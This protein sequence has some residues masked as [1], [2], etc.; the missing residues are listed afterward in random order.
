[1]SHT[2]IKYPEPTEEGTQ[3]APITFMQALK[4]RF[5]HMCYEFNKYR[6]YPP[7]F[8]GMLMLVS[9]IQIYAQLLDSHFIPRVS[10]EWGPFDFIATLLDLIRLSP[11][12]GGTVDASLTL[13]FVY[14]M[15]ALVILFILSFYYMNHAITIRKLYFVL[16]I[17]LAC[18]YGECLLWVL[19]TPICELYVDIYFCTSDNNVLLLPSITCWSTQHSIHMALITIGLVLNIVA[20]FVVA[21]Y[22]NESRPYSATGGED[23]LARLDTN[24]EVYFCSYRVIISLL[25]RWLIERD[26]NWVLLVMH[27]FYAT[28]FAYKYYRYVPYYNAT[29]SGLNGGCIVLHLWLIVNLI[30]YDFLGGDGTANNNRKYTGVAVVI[31]LGMIIIYGSAW[32]VRKQ[33][34]RQKLIEIHHAKITTEEELDLYVQNLLQLYNLQQ[35]KTEDELLLR[36]IVSRHKAECMDVDCPLQKPAGELLYHPATE[37]ESGGDKTNVRDKIVVLSL[38]NSIFKERER[39]LGDQA[40]ACLHLIFGNFLFKEM[41]NIH[42]AIVEV[43]KAQKA[44]PSYQQEISIYQLLRSIEEYLVKRYRHKNGDSKK[45]GDDGRDQRGPVQT[46]ECWDVMVVIKFENWLFQLVKTVERCAAEHIEFWS[47]LE[48]LL[49]DLNELNRL[50]L[51]IL[52]STKEIA[53][54][55]RKISKINPNHP[56]AL[57][58]YGYYLRDIKNDLDTGQDYIERAVSINLHKSVADD[59]NNEFDIMFAEDTAIIVINGCPEFLGKITKTNSGVFKLFGYNPYEIYGNDVSILMP[60]LFAQQHSKFMHRY[61]ESGRQLLIQSENMLFAMHRNNYL[62]CVSVVIKPVA[63]LVSAVPNYIGLLRQIQKEFDFVLTDKHGKIDA[64]SMGIYHTYNI[65]AN[66]IKENQIYIHLICPDLADPTQYTEQKLR[67]KF[68]MIHGRHRLNFVIPRDFTSLAHLFSQTAKDPAELPSIANQHVGEDEMLPYKAAEAP[69]FFNVTYKIYKGKYKGKEFDIQHKNIVKE[70]FDYSKF[71]VKTQAVCDISDATYG[72][73]MLG[74]RIFKVF[75]A[76]MIRRKNSLEDYYGRDEPTPRNGGQKNAMLTSRKVSQFEPQTR[77]AETPVP[78]RSCTGAMD[79]G[80]ITGSPASPRSPISPLKRPTQVQESEQA[81]GTDWTPQAKVSVPGSSEMV[82]M[83]NV[84]SPLDLKDPNNNSSSKPEEKKVDSMGSGKILKLHG[85]VGESA[86]NSTPDPRVISASG[87]SEGVSNTDEDKKTKQIRDARK[88]GEE[89]IIKTIDTRQMEVAKRLIMR[90]KTLIENE[91]QDKKS[92]AAE[93]EQKAEGEE[94]AIK[95]EA[96]SAGQ[97]SE[98][99]KKEEK[100]RNEDIGSVSTTNHGLMRIIHSLQSALN[101]MYSPPAIGQLKVLACLMLVALMAVAIGCFITAGKVYQS[102]DDHLDYVIESQDRSSSIANLAGFTR[103]LS[104]LTCNSS[105]TTGL[106]LNETLV[107]YNTSTIGINYTYDGAAVNYSTWTYSNLGD[108]ADVLKASQTK[109]SNAEADFVS[110][111]GSAVNPEDIVVNQ[112]PLQS[113]STY[114]TTFDC[115]SA[116]NALVIHALK[117][118]SGFVS[119]RTTWK[120]TLNDSLAFILDNALNSV[121]SSLDGATDGL[122]EE[123]KAAAKHNQ[124]MLL[125]FLAVASGAL[126]VFMALVMPVVVKIRRNKQELL[127]LFL[128]IPVR[129]AKN[130]LEKCHL[131]CRMIHGEAEVEHQDMDEDEKNQEKK[132][133]DETDMLLDETKKIT[134]EEKG[135]ERTS[136]KRRKFK[137]YSSELAWLI[138]E[139]VISVTVLESYFLYSYFR[140]N[141]LSNTVSHLMTEVGSIANRMTA[142]ELYYW[143]ELELVATNGTGK[144]MNYVVESYVDTYNSKILSD[145]ETFLQI[146]S[147]NSKY[148]SA[149]YKDL[150]D[151]MI[152]TDVCSKIFDDDTSLSDC[153]S[154]MDGVLE[155]GLNS[156]NVAFWDQLKELANDFRRSQI[157]NKALQDSMLVDQRLIDNHWLMYEYFTKAYETLQIGLRTSMDDLF[158]TEKLLLTV[159]FILYMIF[160]VLIYILFSKV[161]VENT[162]DSLWVTKS[163]LT[164][165]PPEII[166]QVAK[167]RHF[168]LSTSKSM[169]YGL[170]ND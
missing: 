18:L 39:R 91:K 109:L 151:G 22:F 154:Y 29:I 50:G 108:Y 6:F 79:D 67:L 34:I 69:Q 164:I 14:A 144:V 3:S 37:I 28:I 38:I 137:P 138:V 45:A 103:L 89:M 15:L 165:L 139:S 2:K 58:I 19:I 4:N 16:P 61:F 140:A 56:K 143:I 92:T 77:R 136:K 33:L 23:G 24:S 68:D 168:V 114:T 87:A 104:L 53:N 111:E 46:A 17:Q 167:I 64:I 110:S 107:N 83:D 119:N 162:K 129:R 93:G 60:G 31:A 98:N 159:I 55:W 149:S 35:L 66:F 10:D 49:P 86:S 130:Q 132:F 121:L 106:C 124:N 48:S 80:D 118:K 59:M 65:T 42:M 44:S 81:R 157:R 142:N 7:I 122:L 158:D 84:M 85:T 21:F 8:S 30:I 102:L 166:L 74:I 100:K 105:S 32:S 127:C 147:D 123:G 115:A 113:G 161:F 62:I 47:H 57:N 27:F 40:G 41:G 9:Y 82:S 152:Y 96:S 169:I 26:L 51:N 88:S 52:Q 150:F 160:L 90:K 170:K 135:A 163:L 72:G 148:N 12:L 95:K 94:P 153:Q 63:S 78:K 126:V 128:E 131:F 101:E 70:C 99:R 97:A 117:V 120:Y 155:K 11:Q 145:Q 13:A 20:A 141:W 76:K 1:M 71:E 146:H 73:G 5:I 43:M 36:G 133:N 125:I 54:I 112:I 134:G 156:A 75:R 116:V 25:G